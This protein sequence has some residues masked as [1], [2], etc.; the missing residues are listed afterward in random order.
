MQ[1]NA[2]LIDQVSEEYLV[3]KLEERTNLLSCLDIAENEFSKPGQTVVRQL[4][5]DILS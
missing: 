2:N 4:L 3:V 5:V 1:T